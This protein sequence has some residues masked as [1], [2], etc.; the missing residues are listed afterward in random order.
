MTQNT[1]INRK[2]VLNSRPVGAPVADNF[3]LEESA[4]PTPAAGQVL[5]R[6]LYL[7]LDPYMRGRM[8]DAASYAASVVLGEV[9]VGSTVS[10]VENSQHP[11]Y[12]VGDLV[13]AYSGWQDF[14][15]SDG[16]GL[17]K[18]DPAMAHPSLALGALGMPGF[19]A[20]MGLLDIGQ[21][22]AGETVVV[23]AASGAVGSMVGQIAKLKG[24]H[25]VGIAGGAEKCRSVV[26]ELGFDAC[27]DHRSADF[28]AQLAAACPK[29]IDVYFENVGG[30]VFDAVLPL[31]NTAARIPVCGLIAHYNDTALP[32][33]PDRLGLLTRTILTKRIKMQGFIIFDDYGQRYPEFFGQMSSWLKDGKV[34]FREDIVEGLEHAPQAFIGLLEGKNFG[35]LIVRIHP[36]T[37]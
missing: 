26:E 18:L 5:L 31:L 11:D 28:K 30:A 27:I 19:T 3:R 2:I 6:S 24:C 8:S 22:K 37:N 9:M 36:H 34:K 29:G 33:G 35:K 14:A 1:A 32:A 15:I 10:R 23:A 4:V 25:V 12:Q 20:Y 7:S 17:T 21:P 13:L 16:T